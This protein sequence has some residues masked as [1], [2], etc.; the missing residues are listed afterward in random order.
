MEIAVLQCFSVKQVKFIILI[1]VFAVVVFESKNQN[2]GLRPCESV[3]IN[4][5]N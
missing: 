4:N 3:I 1:L 5:K 2:D